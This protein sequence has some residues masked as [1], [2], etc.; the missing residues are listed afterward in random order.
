MA[1]GC[2]RTAGVHWPL[3]G[4]GPRVLNSAFGNCL[5]GY[6]GRGVLQTAGV[7]RARPR[8]QGRSVHQEATSR[9]RRQVRRQGR[10]PFA[11]VAGYRAAA[12]AVTG[13]TGLELRTVRRGMKKPRP[14]DGVEV[15]CVACDG[16]GDPPVQ[17]P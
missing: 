2:L 17:V 12:A 11:G 14:V 8:R 9:S 6:Y 1:K 10:R 4:G 7:A 16:K 3:D 13:E 15:K 5:R